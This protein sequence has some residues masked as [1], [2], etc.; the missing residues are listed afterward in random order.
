M[1]A[2]S[3]DIHLHNF[4]RRAMDRTRISKDALI[5]I[6]SLTGVHSC[7][8]RDVTNCGAGIRMQGLSLLPLNFL[9]SFDRFRTGRECRL[10]WREGDFLGIAFDT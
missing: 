10:I 1:S 7:S 2:T 6:P 5:F 4:E 8:V 9:L 3:G